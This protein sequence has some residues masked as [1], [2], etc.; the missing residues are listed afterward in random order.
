M[1]YTD[2]YSARVL[3][4]A[5]Y[6]I[7][8]DTAGSIAEQGTF[9][10]LGSLGGYVQHL[11]ELQS[12]ISNDRHPDEIDVSA[13]TEPASGIQ[14]TNSTNGTFED[15]TSAEKDE[16]SAYRYYFRAMG[17]FNIAIFFI[18]GFAFTF[19]LRFSGLSFNLLTVEDG[20]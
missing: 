6:I 15:V 12:H 13:L 8:L 3:R 10:E 14:K 17:W 2:L 1:R 19:F 20:C 11:C 7:A 16:K 4:Y 9:E 5:D 18:M